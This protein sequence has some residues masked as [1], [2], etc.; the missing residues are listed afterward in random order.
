M[1]DIVI[2]N[3]LDLTMHHEVLS[4]G[5][6][7]YL[8]PMNDKKRYY[9]TLGTYFGSTTTSFTDYQGNKVTVPNGVAHFL[10]HKVFANKDGVDPMSFYSKSGTECNAST[11]YNNTKYIVLGTKNFKENFEY[12]VNFVTNPYFTDGNVEKE[13]GIIKEEINMYKDEAEERI[14]DDLRA[15]LY[16]NDKHK[17]NVAGEVQDIE[18]ITKEDLYE[19]YNTFYNPNNMFLVITGAFSLEDA[20]SVINSSLSKL[21]NKCERRGEEKFNEPLSPVKIFE[22]KEENVLVPKLLVGIKID[23]RSLKLKDPVKRGLYL[24]AI[25]NSNFGKTSKFY[26]KMTEDNLLN[27]CSFYTENSGNITTIYFGAESTFPDELLEKFKE[28]LQKLEITKE[29]LDRLKKVYTASEIRGSGYVNSIMGS[30]VGDL[31]RYHKVINDPVGLYDSLNIAEVSNIL[32]NLNT[33]NISTVIYVPENM[34]SYSD[35]KK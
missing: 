28:K 6:D 26:E 20:E 11:S 27:T 9:I 21:E 33:D 8:V 12:L 7:V 1:K 24:S 10:E 4:N 31:V 32:K 18:K 30:L 17:Y 14:D 25:I 29:D 34:K 13:K 16:V 19:C 22:K 35:N 15:N 2:M 3:K 5:L 23:N